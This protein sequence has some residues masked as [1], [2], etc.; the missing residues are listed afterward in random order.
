[1]KAA[2]YLR[3]SS[4]RA[5][6]QAGID[7][8]RADAHELIERRGWTKIAEHVDNNRSAARGK[9]RPA[10]DELVRSIKAGE[11]E[12]VVAWTLDRLARNA[13]DRLALIE[14]CQDQRVI[15]AL[16]RGSDIDCSTAHGRFTAGVLGEVAQ[17][18]IDLK[19]E[20]QHRAAEQAAVQ[21]RW[22]G[23]RRPFGYDADGVTVRPD[24]AN[25]IRAAYTDILRG[26][27]LA[28]IAR[29]WNAAG[30]LGG[31]NRYT[32]GREHERSEWRHDSVRHVLLNAR[33]AGIRT[34]R[35]E[36]RGP[37]EWP[38]LVPEETFRA[39]QSVLREPARH[40][41][42][43]G[44]PGRQLLTGIALCG[45]CGRVVH[46][47]GASR[48]QRTYRCARSSFRVS[49]LYAPR[50]DDPAAG[51]HV[52]R[53]AA[54]CDAYIEEMV[55]A[56]LARPDFAHLFQQ[57]TTVDV[58]GLREERAVLDKRLEGLA[59]EFADGDLTASQLRAATKRMRERLTVL[60]EQLAAAG[61]TDL[62]APLI[63]TDDVDRAW[64]AMGAPDE[65][66][67]DR[68]RAVVNL[69]M[70]VHLLSPGRGTRTFRPETVKVRWKTD[71]E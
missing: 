57:N 28:A 50:W 62:L 18:E 49:E 65:G 69:L 29:R 54:P 7:R 71:V 43:L 33:Y 24:E 70:E 44:Y 36:E 56:R 66:G 21:G 20:R 61:R 17:H 25:A 40:S 14:A 35:G 63:D 8:Q 9:H 15:I 11:V 51:H 47:G 10:F 12:A 68:Q 26:V 46:G 4:D 41:G 27:T 52:H 64:N 19:S 2:C 37:A 23:G 67:R 30:L 60:D 16:V 45:R 32:P 5:G 59:V 31:H 38:A 53:Q 3:L 58:A 22:V 42:G 13:R 34:L 1:M 48:S 55:V 39:A 6:D